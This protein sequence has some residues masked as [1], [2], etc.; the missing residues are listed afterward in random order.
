MSEWDKYNET[1]IFCKKLGCKQWNIDNCCPELM[2]ILCQPKKELL[3]KL[4][5]KEKDLKNNTVNLEF[6]KNKENKEKNI[7]F[8]IKD[9]E[10]F[11]INNNND[12]IQVE[13]YISKKVDS[14]IKLI[15]RIGK[16]VEITT[17][18]GDKRC[19]YI[20]YINDNEVVLE[21]KKN[22]IFHHINIKKIK[23]IINI[24]NIK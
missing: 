2:S 7:D 6:I 23:D 22:N 9:E 8:V 24:I 18:Y 20:C 1:M 12:I 5:I 13:R 10:S 17:I 15:F 3:K 14:N 16:K 21:N 4:N 19:G 11:N